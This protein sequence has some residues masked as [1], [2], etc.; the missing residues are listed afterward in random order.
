MFSGE[1]RPIE[2]ETL[3]YAWLVELQ[4]GTF[5]GKITLPQV[6]KYFS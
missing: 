3:E 4:L 5:C 1:D 2:C 6:I